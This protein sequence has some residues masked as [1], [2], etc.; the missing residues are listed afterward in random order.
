MQLELGKL[1]KG[2][3]CINVEEK[4]RRKMQEKGLCVWLG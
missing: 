3:M 1:K 2:K 4:H